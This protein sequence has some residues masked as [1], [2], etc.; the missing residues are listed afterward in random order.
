MARQDDLM[1]S[2]QRVS[3]LERQNRRLRKA[4]LGIPILA[5]LFIAAGSSGA[6]RSA[7]DSGQAA[8]RVE[9]FDEIA[10]VH[11]TI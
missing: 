8:G 3:R 9:K 4:L 11:K 2:V 10:I 7:A 6:R 1:A 5:L